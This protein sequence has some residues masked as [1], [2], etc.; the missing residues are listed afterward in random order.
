M[1]KSQNLIVFVM[2]E[3]R[4]L[5]DCNRKVFLLKYML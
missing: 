5:K 4:L 3:L 2:K 1:L